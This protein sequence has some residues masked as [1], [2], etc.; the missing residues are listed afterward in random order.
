MGQLGKL[1][2]NR[3]CNRLAQGRRFD[4]QGDSKQTIPG[5]INL[6]RGDMPLL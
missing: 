5:R 1:E 4:R 2:R 3:G 6:T